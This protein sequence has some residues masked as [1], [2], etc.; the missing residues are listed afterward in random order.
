MFIRKSVHLSRPCDECVHE[1]LTDDGAWFPRLVAEAGDRDGERFAS[2]GF[3]AAGL[4]LRKRVAV[5]F[6]K[7]RRVGS[8]AEVELAWQP[9]TSGGLLPS[10][11]GR[12]QVAPVEPGVTRVTVSGS[13]Q[14]PLGELGAQLDQV[15][16]NRVAKATVRELAQQ[17]ARELDNLIEARRPQTPAAR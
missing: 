4:P 9:T 15:M 5:R 14:P 16:L 7:P 10:F 12:L 17:V 2:V 3:R 1:L 11:A 13:Y 8:E 6:G